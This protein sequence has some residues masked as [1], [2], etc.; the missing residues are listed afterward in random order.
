MKILLYIVFAVIVSAN[1]VF[2]EDRRIMNDLPA[3]LYESQSNGLSFVDIPDT[4]SNRLTLLPFNTSR[5]ELAPAIRNGCL[6]YIVGD[7]SQEQRYN[8]FELESAGVSES[9]WAGDSTKKKREKSREIKNVYLNFSPDGKTVFLNTVDKKRGTKKLYIGNPENLEEIEALHP[10]YF[11]SR[12]YSIG[13]AT[14]SPDGKLLVFSSDRPGSLGGGDLWICRFE[15]GLWSSPENAGDLI[16]TG[17]DEAMPY[18]YS[19]TRLYF[20]SGGHDGYGGLDLFYSDLEGDHFTTPVNMGM[21]VNSKANETGVCFSSQ[22][23]LFYFA[24]DRRGNYDIY[25]YRPEEE[26]TDSPEKILASEEEKKEPE[27]EPAPVKVPDR[28]KAPEVSV[29]PEPAAEAG[30]NS[31]SPEISSP[32][33]VR[34]FYVLQIMAVSPKTYAM[35]YYRKVLDPDKKY[36]LVRED[37]WMKIRNSTDRFSSYRKAYRFATK[38]KLDKFYIV[39]MSEEQISE[40]L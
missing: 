31:I 7:D 28:V 25:S 11:N 21:P 5:H 16:N 20:A 29:V 1:T 8:V 35:Q 19:N 10:F 17:L 30:K 37:G 26:I 4:C 22:T 15:T 36:F 38:E 23:G 34:Y 13:R 18:F 40:Y 14:L 27:P 24:S 2:A 39:R 3:E 9:S 32:A 33:P 12:K 6:S